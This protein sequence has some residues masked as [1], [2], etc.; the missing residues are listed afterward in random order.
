[1]TYETAL[2]KLAA[3]YAV[4]FYGQREHCAIMTTE[5]AVKK[6]VWT[7]TKVQ[8]PYRHQNE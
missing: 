6:P 3:F 7:P 1:M 4:H 8:S 5:A 2:K